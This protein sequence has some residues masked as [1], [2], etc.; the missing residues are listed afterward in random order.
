MISKYI[1]LR[2]SEDYN[3]LLEPAD[4]IR[5]GKLVVVPTETVYGIGANALDVEAV[6]N[7]FIAKGRMQDNPLIVHIANISMLDDLI[8]PAGEIEQALI[9][10]FW[11]GPLTIVFNKKEVVPRIVTGGL[12]TVAIRM[13]SNEIARKLIEYSKV[14]IA[15]PSA[16][17]SGRPSGTL[18]EDIAAELDGK[19][20]YMIDGGA[21][22]IGLES[23]VV[24]VKNNVV[25]I[26]RPGKVTK[27][28]LEDLGL[29][30][31]VEGHIL[32]EYKSNES[33][34][35]PGMKYKHYAPKTKCILVYSKDE[36]KLVA[37][38][39]ELVEKEDKKVLV[40]AKT[41]NLDK[42]NIDFKID[43]GE[44]LE[45]ISKNI[46]SILRKVD[47]YE[48][49][50]AIIEGVSQEGLGLALMNRLIRACENN[51]IEI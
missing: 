30:V 24:R 22:D 46:F 7:I 41:K 3:K 28:Q 2:K 23:T 15:A 42:Y 17:I 10:N 34:M 48:A 19:V 32:G 1:D 5:E 16:N 35:S 4:A 12:N 9:N 49:D 44:T 36:D 21:V 13:P 33:V 18:L 26:L 50:L 29:Q 37:K 6:K 47:S 45:D 25:H 40:L 38:I 8:E 43:I 14:P 31:K 51:Y 20:E 11:P 27:E 39:N